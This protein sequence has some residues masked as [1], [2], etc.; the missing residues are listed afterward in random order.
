MNRD[1][2]LQ[3]LVDL[4]PFTGKRLDLQ[5]MRLARIN[6]TTAELVADLA[7]KERTFPINVDME[8]ERMAGKF[9]PGDRVQFE[10]EHSGNDWLVVEVFENARAQQW[11]FK[12]N[13]KAARLF[14]VKL[15]QQA[16]SESKMDPDANLDEM[17]TLTEDPNRRLDD[18][19]QERLVEL[20]QA[21]DRWLSHKGF[22]PKAWAR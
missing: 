16:E 11:N 14:C 13:E 8:C 9:E 19:E 15:N 3:A 10:V 6:D 1:E 18:D 4:Q 2:L 20:F 22:L 5:G 12:R 7:W 21:L 17:R